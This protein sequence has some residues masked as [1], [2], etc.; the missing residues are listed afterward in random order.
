MFFFLLQQL[1]FLVILPLCCVFTCCRIASAVCVHS[2]IVPIFPSLSPFFFSFFILGP[3][4][5]LNP[6]A[7]G[8]FF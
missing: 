7:K 6:F 3:D 5:I 2:S 8:N 1:A 4:E